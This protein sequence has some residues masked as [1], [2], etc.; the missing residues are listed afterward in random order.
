LLA[1]DVTN[2]VVP[3]ICNYCSKIASNSFTGKA[4][5]RDATRQCRGGR[6]LSQSDENEMNRKVRWVICIKLMV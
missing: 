5:T 3:K 6:Y 4:N 2:T 1:L